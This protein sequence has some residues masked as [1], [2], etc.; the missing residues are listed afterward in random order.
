MSNSEDGLNNL[1]TPGPVVL[2]QLQPVHGNFQLKTGN[3]QMK[4]KGTTSIL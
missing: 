1:P 2:P 3:R 4:Q